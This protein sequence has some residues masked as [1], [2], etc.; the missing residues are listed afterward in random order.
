MML[1]S[2]PIYPYA[3]VFCFHRRTLLRDEMVL[4]VVFLD[5]IKKLS[6][7]TVTSPSVDLSECCVSQNFILTN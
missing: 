4:L 2:P 6:E 3:W 5:A 1:F 7:V